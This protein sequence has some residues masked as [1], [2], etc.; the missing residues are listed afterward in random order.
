MIAVARRLRDLSLIW[1][2]VSVSLLFAI[3]IGLLAQL[4][5]TQSL[6]DIRFAEREAAGVETLRELWPAYMAVAR[7]GRP[8][9]DARR[10][11]ARRLQAVAADPAYA[12]PAGKAA[13]AFGDA[14]RQAATSAVRALVTAVSDGS[15]LTLD[16]DLDSYYLMD[17]LVFK[18]TEIVE[19]A[20][21][22]DLAGTADP[23]AVALA[24]RR[25]EAAAGALQSSVDAAIAG[26]GGGPLEAALTTPGAD[27]AAAAKAYAIAAG[28]A[29]AAAA[30]GRLEGASEAF[31]T[32][33]TAELTG[34]LERR[35]DGFRAR[36]QSLLAIAGAVTAVTLLLVGLVT[37]DISRSLDRIVLRMTTLAEGDLAGEVP[38]ADRPNELGR[39]A[40]SVLVF[41]D[42]LE[43]I[44][45]LR[46]ERAEQE[47]AMSALRRAD[48]QRL[49]VAFESSVGGIA[50]AVA[51]AAMQLEASAQAL[52]A[53]SSAADRQS[54]EIAASTARTS[55][56]LK[57]AAT[58]TE[59]LADA[60]VEMG[61]RAG[62]QARLA[63]RAADQSAATGAAA[64][65][66]AAMADAVGEI[67]DTIRAIAEQTN[68]LAL[69]AT[70]EAARAGEAG[71]GFSVVAAEVKQLADETARATD[72]IAGQV[73]A[74][75][76]R[77]GEVSA[78][79]TEIGGSIAA[80]NG[81]AASVAAAV[82][83]QGASAR[84]IAGT[85]ESASGDAARLVQ[86]VARVGRS[87]ADGVASAGEVLAA[88][89]D[90]ARQ[91]ETL[92]TEVFHFLE[93]VR[94]A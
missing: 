94:A 49:A 65:D 6:K 33:G 69:N 12:G 37:R 84:G 34:L 62:E 53:A 21:E 81:I 56:R 40:R 64:G 61:V 26:N 36:L 71:Q 85:V 14:D 35:A 19:A 70:I 23:I 55:D 15:S 82:V 20:V 91:A 4:F 43:R 87:A 31:F 89:G 1:K 38:F 44:E 10:D 2:L 76:G 59:A 80:V 74:I 78:A 60:V 32:V 16:P 72:R 30:R 86:G 22:R 79:V 46:A 48:V 73:Q 77:I 29:D 57:T 41:R 3:P 25:L 83:A 42:A 54:A 39:I 17:A 45:R 28:G 50:R 67:V 58:E 7:P 9:E 11:A 52:T 63:N 8:D 75:R 27:L 93:S 66:L 5:V 18:L 90:L 13:E 92:N 24:V 68:L 51:T 88:A 47:Q